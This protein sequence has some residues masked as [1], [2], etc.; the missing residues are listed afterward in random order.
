M[1]VF[2]KAG[3]DY[4][5]L[6]REKPSVYY[7]GTI[8]FP[9]DNLRHA[10]RHPEDVAA[11]SCE[12][13]TGVDARDPEFAG[14]FG[15]NQNASMLFVFVKEAPPNATT[16]LPNAFVSVADLAH[17]AVPGGM[18]PYMYLSL[19]AVLLWARSKKP[20]LAVR[21]RAV[22]SRIDPAAIGISRM[23]HPHGT[24]LLGAVPG[25]AAFFLM[26]HASRGAT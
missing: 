15:T 22:L 3:D 20:D 7:T 16:S 10:G 5:F 25:S 17:L 19:R 1:V 18:T 8:V 2:R 24:D 4:E 14:W 26:K 13:F 12:L 23:E 21:L 9:G 11:E 6:V